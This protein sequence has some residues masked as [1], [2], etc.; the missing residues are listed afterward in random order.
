MPDRP[1]TFPLARG[2][3]QRAVLGEA[4]PEDLRHPDGS[5]QDL[6]YCDLA[7]SPGPSRPHGLGRRVSPPT[8]LC[9]QPQDRRGSGYARRGSDTRSTRDEAGTQGGVRRIAIARGSTIRPS[10][11]DQ[12]AAG[13]VRRQRRV[14]RRPGPA[15]GDRRHSRYD[16]Q[17]IAVRRLRPGVQIPTPTRRIPGSRHALDPRRGPFGACIPATHRRDRI[18]ATA[19]SRVRP[20]PSHGANCDIARRRRR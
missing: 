19:M 14:A 10:I 4:I 11:G 16:R 7:P 15:G 9:R 13:C 3:L 2:S 17:P 20:I 12:H 6:N 5:R 8:R 1:S 18:G